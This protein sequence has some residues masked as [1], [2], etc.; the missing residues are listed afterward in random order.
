MTSQ[1]K[2]YSVNDFRP[3]CIDMHSGHIEK[4]MKGFEIKLIRMRERH[5]VIGGTTFG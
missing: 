4:S 1:L 5:N 3:S 2:S